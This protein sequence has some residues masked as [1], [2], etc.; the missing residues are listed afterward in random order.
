MLLTDSDISLMQNND[1]VRH[2]SL[3][4][5]SKESVCSGN[6]CVKERTFLYASR[7]AV[8]SFGRC[9]K[10]INKRHKE[11]VTSFRVAKQFKSFELWNKISINM[12][13][14]LER[15]DA[16]NLVPNTVAKTSTHS[17]KILLIFNP[18]TH[19]FSTKNPPRRSRGKVKG[20]LRAIAADDD[21]ANVDMT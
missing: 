15:F 18:A 17:C 7:Q 1:G 19:V 8:T 3:L 13:S 16:D 14:L 2:A 20:P 11:N 4:N 5:T 6:C 9:C 10:N 21:G 12:S